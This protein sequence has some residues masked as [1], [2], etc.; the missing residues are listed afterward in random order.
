MED[1]F[2]FDDLVPTQ[3][4]ESPVFNVSF[5]EL[6]PEVVDLIG[7][8]VPSRSLPNFG[9][10]SSLCRVVA[11]RYLYRK[12]TLLG[13][14]FHVEPKFRDIALP[15][16]GGPIKVLLQAAKIRSCKTMAALL[17]NKDNIAAVREF[18]IDGYP[19]WSDRPYFLSIVKYLWEN[20]INLVVTDHRY[21][22]SRPATLP[23]P[24]WSDT[25]RHLET[26]HICWWVQ[27]AISGKAMRHLTFTGCTETAVKLR[28]QGVAHITHL[29]YLWHEWKE[30]FEAFNYDWI[31]DAFPNLRALRIGVCSCWVDQNI[32]EK[33]RPR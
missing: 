11:R 20:M 30:D 28:D 19:S 32:P 8:Y 31:A 3:G 26:K 18:R 14:L 23:D 10:V 33:A 4:E 16:S 22:P 17:A 13:N 21:F 5:D 25:L 29:E 6:P 9:L 1:L 27:K 24:C 15:K 7:F 2:P 12:V